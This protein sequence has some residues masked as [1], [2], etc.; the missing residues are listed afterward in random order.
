MTSGADRRRVLAGLAFVGL[1]GCERSRPVVDAP[2]PDRTRPIDLS[3]LEKTHG[4][5]IGLYAVDINTVS[6]RGDERFLYCSTFKLFLAAAT[7]ERIQHHDETLDR[8]VPITAADLVPYAP[9]VEP[10]V[11]KT[12]TIETL[13]RAAVEVS[14]NAAANILLR[15]MG[16]L[17]TL[18]AYYRGIGDETTRLDRIEPE[19]NLKDGDKDTA[20]PR[21]TAINLSW[22]VEVYQPLVFGSD[23]K[24]LWDWM[25]DSPTGMGRIKAG[26]PEGWTVAHKT[27]TSG[28]GQFNDIAVV[29]PP[30]GEPIRIAVYYDAPET[31]KTA[32]AEGVIAEATRRA[33][34]AL[35]SDAAA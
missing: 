8:A 35:A 27:G 25:I 11:G 2:Q 6:W 9:V 19:L 30:M 33:I 17:E 13:M 1:A 15:E 7:L 24:P 14:D 21:Q 22:M 31:L 29:Y 4:G 28:K 20:Q 5:R 16:G 23:Y 32:E 12:L 34:A 26:T 3:D 10:A 18:R